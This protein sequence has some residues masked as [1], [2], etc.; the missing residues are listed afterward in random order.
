MKLY[1]NNSKIYTHLNRLLILKDYCI[2]DDDTIIFWMFAE[3]IVEFSTT[4][5]SLYLYGLKSCHF[6]HHNIE[7]NL[8]CLDFEKFFLVIQDDFKF[9]VPVEKGTGI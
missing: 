9:S 2:F 5:L 4:F 8:T 1:R 6:F 3:I 7:N